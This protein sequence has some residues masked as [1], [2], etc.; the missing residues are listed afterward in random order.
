[1][2]ENNRPPAPPGTFW[3]GN[4]LH[5]RTRVK[6]QLYRWSLETSDP[7]VAA[8]KY[9]EKKGKLLT[10]V[11]DAK[12]GIRY[13]SDV[14]EEWSPWIKR[15]VGPATTE[16]YACSLGQLDRWLD[17]KKVTDIDGPLV[18]KIIAERSK[19]VSNA[20]IKRDLG[21]LSSV[22]NFCIDQGYRE[23]N[24]VLPRMRRV[25]ERRDPIVL[26][27]HKHIMVAITRAPPMMGNLI[28]A[29]MATG[30]RQE[31]LLRARRDHIDDARGQMTLIGKGNKL[32]VIDLAP[33]DGHRLLSSLPA[34][35]EAPDRYLFWHD[36]GQRYSTSFK[37]NFRKFI[38]ITDKWAKENGVDFRPFRF[39]DLRHW[40][41]VHFLK[42]GLGTIY[43]LKERLGHTNISVTEGYLKYLTPDEHRRAK[44][45]ISSSIS[46]PSQPV[47]QLQE[48]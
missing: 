1:M 42:N 7:E 2:S 40:H 24:P 10:A 27:S 23:D 32:R 37:S 6:G 21:A 45:G 8:R 20:T 41:A 16:R 18:A 47:P 9:R 11:K 43:A 19:D 15:Q 22:I 48:V 29:A 33:F 39:H 4:T 17:G 44:D 5:G 26:P 36:D 31:E 30:A 34:A 14:V 35:S 25:K 13:F 38:M 28:A 3:R 46:P 12:N